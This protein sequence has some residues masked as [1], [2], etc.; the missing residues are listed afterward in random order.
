MLLELG[1]DGLQVGRKVA[2]EEEEEVS[3]GLGVG[4]SSA[5]DV[6]VAVALL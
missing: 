1:S 3:V 2:Y 5:G 4:M 6:V